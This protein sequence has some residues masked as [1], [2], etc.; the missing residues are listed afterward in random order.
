MKI[1]AATSSVDRAPWWVCLVRC[2]PAMSFW[3]AN[4]R[5]P[6]E[7]ARLWQRHGTGKKS[8]RQEKLPI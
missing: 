2:F 4:F 8:F 5:I 1:S 7:K 3:I 6:I